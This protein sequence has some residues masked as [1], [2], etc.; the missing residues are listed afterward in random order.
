[1]A[2]VDSRAEAVVIANDLVS[3][4]RVLY[5]EIYDHAGEYGQPVE[6]IRDATF[7]GNYRRAE[8]VRN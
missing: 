4:D 1:M 6:S 3:G 8:R 5:C 2:I 7:R